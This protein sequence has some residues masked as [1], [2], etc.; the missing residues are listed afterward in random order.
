MNGSRWKAALA[1][2]LIAV[3]SLVA[4][5]GKSTTSSSSADTAA[6]GATTA[7]AAT[8]PLITPT[9]S[10][11][12]GDLTWATYR[13]TNSLDPIYAFDYPENN[14]ITMM[15]ES[16]LVQQA[17][18]SITQTGIASKIDTS[19]P[20]KMVI[21]L[22]DGV[23]FWDG[24][25]LTADDVIY[26]LGRS[27]D[28]KLG[29]FYSQ[30]FIRVES[31]EATAPNT[32]TITLNQPDTWLYGELSS[33]PG[34]I[35]EK[36]FAE[37]AGADFGT[38]KGGTMCTGG[39]KL[40]SWKTGEGVKAV[41][42]DAYWDT[43]NMPMASSITLKGFPDEATL[44]SSLLTGE[45]DG[46]YALN[47]ST[48]DQLK[49]AT[50]KVTVYQG[51]SEASD[52]FIISSFK[53]TLGDVRVRQALS[54]VMDREGIVATN[55][56]GAGTPARTLSNVG[57][58][59]YAPEV[60]QAGYDALPAPKV[61]IESAKALIKAAGAEGKIVRIG[62]SSEIATNATEAKALQ[63]AAESIGLKAELVSASAANYINFFIDAK[64]REK[65]D[66]FFTVN[67][68]DYADPAAMLATLALEGGSQNYS[69][70]SNPDVTKAMDAARSEPDDAKRAAAVV[71][72][73][74]IITEEVPWLPVVM[75][76]TIL[77]MNNKVT[78]VP[79][80][81]QYMFGPWALKLGAK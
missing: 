44:T 29:G 9:A 66:G 67:Y 59:G 1:V 36:A 73:Q 78:G 71:A 21:T 39:Y 25:P 12:A 26:S 2:G 69:G 33:M 68:G 70:Y 64:A 43:A 7:A 22:R 32:V 11:L 56:K 47:L 31:I 42:N 34:V 23:M 13:E 41:K 27:R 30:A 53:G 79:T 14:A 40:D 35:Y 65:V 45:L 60:F 55:Y 46:T 61:D 5:C 81:F 37:K 16:L 58:Y 77:I 3:A 80:S 18:G 75:P 48:L 76:A 63:S 54:M 28:A 62:M 6:D 24:N 57:T 72:A 52:A 74:K 19:D 8:A 10:G 49:A 38:V 15:C 20:L 51:T 50:D 4:A 17:D